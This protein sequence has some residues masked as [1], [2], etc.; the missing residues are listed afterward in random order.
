MDILSI[1]FPLTLLFTAAAMVVLR[2]GASRVFFDVVGTF[3]ANRLIAD[4]DAK[5]GVVNSIILDGLA[6]IGESVTLI[7]DQMQQLVES[8]VPLAREVSEARLE[9]EKFAS[10]IKGAEEL[11]QEIIGIGESY[12]FTATQAME[13]GSKMAQLSGIF[14]EQQ[15]IAAATKAGITFGMIGNMETEDAM[16]RIIQLHQ[17][18]MTL[19]GGISQQQFMM[20]SAEQQ[21]NII[22][23][24]SARLLNQL[25]TIENRSA[26]TMS[27]VTHVMNQFASSAQLAG[28]SISYMAAM[29]ATLIEA[30]E[31]QGK[32]GRALRM[33]Y[34][35]LGANTGNNAE[36]LA[37]FGIAT[38]DASGNLRT[39]EDIM[40]DITRSTIMNSEADQ[41]R[42]AQAIAGND[43]YVRALKL[44]NNHGRALTL[45]RQALL[46]LDDAQEEA[47]KKLEDNLY[48]LKESEAQLHNSKAA[49]G[50]ALLPAMILQVQVQERMNRGLSQLV[51]S[52]YGEEI[53][54][55]AFGIQTFVRGMAPIGEAVLNMMSLNVSLKTQQT[56]MRALNQEE[57]VRA[58][59]YGGRTAAQQANLAMLDQEL[60][61]MDLIAKLATTTLHMEKAKELT[62]RTGSIQQKLL[63]TNEISQLRN[64]AALTGIQLQNEKD[65]R[66]EILMIQ[67]LG[68]DAE[69]QDLLTGQNKLN[70]LRNEILLEQSL[71]NTKSQTLFLAEEKMAAGLY[72]KGL[73]DKEIGTEIHLQ[74]IMNDNRFTK[75]LSSNIQD[76]INQSK[77]K[78]A[79]LESQINTLMGAG[80]NYGHVNEKQSQGIITNKKNELMLIEQQLQ[81]Q[82]MYVLAENMR[83]DSVHANYI[84]QTILN[85]AVARG[86]TII[87]SKESAQTKANAVEALAANVASQLAKAYKL[88]EAPLRQI[89]AM[90]PQFTAMTGA[91]NAQQ[92]KQMATQMKMNMQMMKLSGILGVASMALMMFTEN[93]ELLR[94]GM[95]LMMASMVPT[96]FGMINMTKQTGAMALG[97]TGVAATA[98][99]AAAGIT[100]FQKAVNLATSSTGIGLMV[101]ALALTISYFGDFGDATKDATNETKNLA[102]AATYTADQFKTME[103]SIENLS[104]L[105][106]SNKIA[107]TKDEIKKLEEDLADATD[108]TNRKHLERRI[109]LLKSEFAIMNDIYSMESA[110]LLLTGEG[111]DGM[112]SR[113]VYNLA[114][115]YQNEADAANKALKDAKE[116]D[117]RPFYADYGLEFLS[118]IGEFVLPGDREEGYSWMGE[119][120][121]G[122]AH[123]VRALEGL[124]QQLLKDIPKAYHGFVLETAKA[125]DSFTDFMDTITDV[126]GEETALSWFGEGITDNIIG[127]L[128]AAKA[129]AFEFSNAREEMFFGMAKGNITGEMVKHVVNK[130]VETLVASTEVIM[131]NNFNGMTTKQ[132]A[133]QILNQI[134][135]GMTE[136]GINLDAA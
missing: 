78:E 20:M 114:Q 98:P 16:K 10:S 18:T 19:Y 15:A 35:R 70:S 133:E 79:N 27:Q 55:I 99:K 7:T 59:A 123:R 113:E 127:P 52:H 6:G 41:L 43:H 106:L 74:K 36:I 120:A 117:D 60:F 129:A 21:A 45:N 31:E 92:E 125:S 130:G 121:K 72:Q 94:A 39:M 51:G 73:K 90:L 5:I 81:K 118:D 112:S 33:M 87:A 25:N 135:H 105:E 77:Q 29:S 93:E 89:I 4:V 67:I 91:L 69:K 65:A 71:Q 115:A 44:M 62:R 80:I 136:R 47:N 97:F 110:R 131:T 11:R 95:I 26:A 32:A 126:V 61:K 30:G 103:A 64:K 37:E 54:K 86:A 56:I 134:E 8:T 12:G 14:G 66:H 48:L 109:A 76:R 96:M 111:P 100:I 40:R 132:A 58:S 63:T 84:G 53:A 24:E 13:A 2:A 3:Q 83:G 116:S 128:E 102:A 42:V 104:H 1:L 124:E 108:A 119:F 49:L 82:G 17:Q 34:A 107:G 9:F 57:I 22:R 68:S 88:Q 46:E 75:N 85:G 122:P 38:K 28:D 101:T 23:G 50:N